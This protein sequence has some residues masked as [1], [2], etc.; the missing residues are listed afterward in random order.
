MTT[1]ETWM[2]VCVRER[3][4]CFC[5]KY[6]YGGGR[7][8][9]YEL[10]FYWLY[11]ADDWRDYC[12]VSLPCCYCYWCY[13]CLYCYYSHSY[14]YSSHSSSHMTCLPCYALMYLTYMRRFHSRTLHLLTFY[15]H[16]FILYSHR[17]HSLLSAPILYLLSP[18]LTHPALHPILTISHITNISTCS[19]VSIYSCTSSMKKL[20]IQ[21]K[22][23]VHIPTLCTSLILH[24]IEGIMLLTVIIRIL[25]KY[26]LLVYSS[27]FL[28]IF[29]VIVTIF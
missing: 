26:I 18:L 15:S 23:Y 9:L 7:C 17:C 8:L 12:L 19:H 14:L 13:Y 16:C 6:C 3:N 5:C 20:C 1:I 24:D 10:G 29:S 27:F 28:T 22:T 11:V 2:C 4:G 21:Y 25:A